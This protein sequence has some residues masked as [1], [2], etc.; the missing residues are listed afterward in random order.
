MEITF[1]RKDGDRL[2]AQK[3]LPGQ[4]IE[5]QQTVLLLHGGGQ[6]RHSWAGTAKALAKSGH[7]AITMDL[8]GHGDSDWSREGLYTFGHFAE[9]TDDVVEQLIEKFGRKPVIIGAS[10]GGMGSMVYVGNGGNEQLSALVLVDI[11]PQV[12]LEGVE[13]ILGFMAEHADEGFGSLEEAADVI[14]AYLPHRP[15]PKDL[16][17]LKKNL[18]LGKDGRYRWHWDPA[19]ISS[20]RQLDDRDALERALRDGVRSLTIPVML[21]RGRESEL[22]GEEEVADFLRLAPHAQV[23]DVSGAR[24]M[25]AGDKNDV[26]TSAVLEFIEKI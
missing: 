9:D 22:V 15:K 7:L 10:L 17:G 25:V 1:T 19:F 16:S 2:V 21:V 6:T 26:F 13:K 24:H 3:F 4:E 20:R 5:N 11:T 18:R 23:A 14:A 12:K 8:R